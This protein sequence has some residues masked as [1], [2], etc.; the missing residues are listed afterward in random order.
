MKNKIKSQKNK[1]FLHGLYAF[2]EKRQK[3]I[4]IA[5]LVLASIVFYKLFD[6][7]VNLAGDD[8]EYIVRAHNLITDGTY[9]T[10]Q[11]ALYPMFLSLLI[12]L[13]GV[14]IVLMK[15]FSAFFYLVHILFFT[16]LLKIGF[17]HSC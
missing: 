16:K 10:F 12:I 17:I 13:G 6:I 2:V 9:P 1:P 7:R 14:N 8:T 15:I 11:G 4:F 5:T 3:V